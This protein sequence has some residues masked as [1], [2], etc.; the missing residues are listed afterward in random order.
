MLWQI[1]AILQ[2][3][4]LPSWLCRC[5]QQ[6]NIADAV[7]AVIGN[8]VILIVIADQVVSPV[9][10]GNLIWID[11]IVPRCSILVFSG[12]ELF[13]CTILVVGKRHLFPFADGLVQHVNRIKKL[14]AVPGLIRQSENMLYLC[15][16]VS[17]GKPFNLTDEFLALAVWSMLGKRETVDEQPQFTV[18]KVTNQIKVR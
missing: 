4:Y 15:F 10:C 5:V 2:P 12:V 3:L 16:E 14:I 13:I 9:D 7:Q 1:E 8:I 17:I 11:N 6:F 18:G